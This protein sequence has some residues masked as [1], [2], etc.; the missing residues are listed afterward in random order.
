MV[1]AP[2]RGAVLAAG[3]LLCVLGLAVPAAAT[4]QL[5]QTGSPQPVDHSNVGATHSPQLLRQF[6]STSAGTSGST[7]QSSVIAGALQGVDVASYQ[8]PSGDPIDWPQVAADGI[9]FAAIKGTEGAYYKNPHALTDLAQAKAAGLSVMAYAFAIPNGNGSSSSPATQADYLINYLAT[10]SAGI[11]AIMLDIEYDPYITTDGTNLCYGLTQS[12]MVSWI[13]AFDAEVQKRTG[14]QPIIYTPPS[15]WKTCTGG[16]AAFSQLPLW[17]PD[18]STTSSPPLPA[19]W[20]NWGLWQYTSIGTVN[21]I[22]DAGHTDLDQLNPSLIALLNPGPQRFLAGSPVGLQIKPADPVAGQTLSYTA[23]GLPRGVSMSPSGQITGW[24]VTP[25]AFA[26]TV[27]ASNGQGLTGTVSFT[28][29]ISIPADAGPAGA[30]RLDLGGKCLNDVGNSS[31]NG[32]EADI[33]TCNGSSAQ[34]WTYVQDGTLRI[35]AKCLAVPSGAASGSKVR[36]ASCTDSGRQQWQLVYPR[37]V[38]TA[39]GGFA[40]TLFNSASG[41]CMTDPGWS[42]K[43]GTR[44]VV[45]PCNGYRNEAWTLPAGPAASGIPGKCLDDSGNRTT[46]GNKIDIYSC[47][48]TTAQQWTVNPDGTLRVHGMCLDV[49]MPGTVSGSL[50]DLNTCS[51]SASQQWHLLRQGGGAQ[52]ANAASNLCLA[53]PGDTTANGTQ[54]QILACT[55]GDPGMA[56]RV[57]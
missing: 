48:G 14:Q 6:A 33:W 2:S 53:D 4:P 23:T 18:Y 15:W 22:N 26:V 3:T 57:S 21:G 7:L 25:G 55:T 36:L 5:A 29:T 16:S 51:G 37:S 46:A 56:W 32:T 8:H 42:R 39:A 49:S 45:S 11:P 24:P 30:V 52:L 13:S 17:V 50:I 1:R 43:D 27:T 10:G 19:G 40:T 12:A 9:Q 47:N 20:A 28:W 44:V 54:M 34:Q 41:M 35:H 38:N 31:A